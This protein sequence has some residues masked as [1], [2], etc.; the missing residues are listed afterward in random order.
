MN[1]TKEKSRTEQIIHCKHWLRQNIPTTFGLPATRLLLE[2]LDGVPV[3]HVQTLGGVALVDPRAVEREA[4]GLLRQARPLAVS[5]HQLLQGGVLLDL[6]LDDIAIL[7]H[8]L[9]NI[10]P[11]WYK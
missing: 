5:S 9:Q 7:A 1:W 4:N 2:D 3:L 6:E 8:Y 11:N 10:F